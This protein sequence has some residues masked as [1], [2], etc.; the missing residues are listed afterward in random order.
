MIFLKHVSFTETKYTFKN[1]YISNIISILLLH[2]FLWIIKKVNQCFF[3]QNSLPE[4]LKNVFK[5]KIEIILIFPHI[6]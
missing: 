1:I 2:P 4:N 3:G 6:N 5:I